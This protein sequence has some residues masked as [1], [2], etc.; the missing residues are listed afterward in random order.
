MKKVIDGKYQF[1]EQGEGPVLVLLHGLFGQLSNFE[2]C[3]KHFSSQ[4]RVIALQLPIYELPMLKA[5]LKSLASHLTDFLNHMQFSKVHLLGNSLGGHVALLY[6][7]EHEHRL[8]SLCLTGSSGLYENAFGGSFPRRGDK[9]FLR[10]RIEKTFYDAQMA[11]DALV[12]E[13][14]EAV[15]N[16]EKLVRILQMAKS[17]IRT[18]LRSELSKITLPTCLIWGKNDEITPPRVAEEFSEKIKSAELFW[19]DQ[20]GH[21]AMMEHPEKFNTLYHNWLSKHTFIS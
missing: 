15:N 6:A 11:T 8:H 18:N 16:K 2:G 1:I 4:F 9:N 20:C 7:L 19:I 12:D 17:A 13:C 14:Y 21:A 10:A 5:N 3:I